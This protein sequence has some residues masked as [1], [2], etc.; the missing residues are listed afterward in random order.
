MLKKA[1]TK[2]TIGF[3]VTFLSLM[4]FQSGGPAPLSLLSGYAHAVHTPGF[5]A[6]V[7]FR[8]LILQITAV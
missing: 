3:F 5:F 4:A 2:E 6:K 1:E 7:V 8:D